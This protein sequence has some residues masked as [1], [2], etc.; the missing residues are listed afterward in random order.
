M[1]VPREMYDDISRDDDDLKRWL[2]SNADAL[3]FGEEFDAGS[4]MPVLASGYAPDVNVVD[5]E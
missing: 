3:L 2:K 1:K 5:L 4:V